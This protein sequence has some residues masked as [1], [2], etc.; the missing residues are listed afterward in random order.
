MSEKSCPDCNQTKSIE[1][2]YKAG[3]YYQTRC[4]LCH[5]QKRTNLYF[6]KKTPRVN[7]F[8]KQPEEI[9]SVIIERLTNGDK[10]KKICNDLGLNYD[11]FAYYR[12]AKLLVV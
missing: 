1:E 7:A 3:A 9:K 4:K 10:L 6:E 5:N 2:F 12:K 11:K 8:Q